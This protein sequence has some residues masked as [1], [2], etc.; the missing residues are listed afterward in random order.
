MSV[1][2]R[3]L[4]IRKMA[5]ARD[6]REIVRDVDLDVP[7]GKIVA[8]MGPNGSGKTTLVGA[9][10]GH[11]KYEMTDGEVR[12][13][14]RIICDQPPDER[15]RRGLFLS[16]QSVPEIPGLSVAS[17]LRAALA[18]RSGKPVAAV[19]L[20]ELK[21]R[22]SEL[23]LSEGFAS[24]GLN[25]NFS[26]GEKKRLE[27]LQLLMLRPRYAL[28]D[29]I[30]AGLDT[31][32]LKILAASLDK[33]RRAGAG[34]LLVTHSPRIFR[35]IKPDAVVVISGGRI[36][37]RGGRELAARIEKEGYGWVTKAGSRE[38]GVGR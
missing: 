22:L 29:E 31:D 6:G 34:I 17:F 10:M 5:V 18:A 25:E 37:A 16:M 20:E 1:R 28:L 24:R 19:F 36:A 30:D 35:V 4:S 23:G 3:S 15:A 32:A 2:K 12:L 13:D 27:L 9:V 11:P 14:G 8:L 26:G 38:M 33:I 7:A 21:R